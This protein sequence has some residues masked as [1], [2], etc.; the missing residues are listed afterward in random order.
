MKRIVFVLFVVLLLAGVDAQAKVIR[1]GNQEQFDQLNK[2]I[3]ECIADGISSITIRVGPGNYYFKER[4]LDLSD[5]KAPG[6]T[7]KM[8]GEKRFSYLLVEKY[9]QKKPSRATTITHRS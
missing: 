4:H 8:V 5:I 1:I 9:L 3:H 7:M 6:L 2:T